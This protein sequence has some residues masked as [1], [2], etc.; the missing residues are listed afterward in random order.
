MPGDVLAHRLQALASAKQGEAGQAPAGDEERAAPDAEEDDDQER[1]AEDRAGGRR[2]RDRERKHRDRVD[3]PE[4]DDREDDRLEAD[5]NTSELLQDP[6]LDQVVEAEGQDGAA[7]R[8][9]TDRCE[10][11][12]LV[13]ALVGWEEPMPPAG[14]EDVAGEVGDRGRSGE[15]R[16]SVV[17]RP[18]RAVV[19]RRATSTDAATVSSAKSA[20]AT[21]RRRRGDTERRSGR[22]T[23]ISRPPRLAACAEAAHR[24]DHDCTDSAGPPRRNY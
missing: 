6:D 18:A 10:T 21:W 1:T 24:I 5:P 14:A 22:P 12:A 11:P 13:G 3:H 19:R 4:R 15:A 9:R 2:G 17:E 16:L 20:P 8:R 7:C 23:M